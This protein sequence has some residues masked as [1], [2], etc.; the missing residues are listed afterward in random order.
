MLHLNQAF[1]TNSYSIID[2][3]KQQTLM[4]RKKLVSEKLGAEIDGL[5]EEFA[6]D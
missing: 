4:Q 3:P 2:V 1:A 5:E 6:P